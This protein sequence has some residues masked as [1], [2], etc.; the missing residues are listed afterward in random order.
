MEDSSSSTRDKVEDDGWVAWAERCIHRGSVDS[1]LHRVH[2]AHLSGA[3]TRYFCWRQSDCAQRPCSACACTNASKS[4]MFASRF[5]ASRAL[6]TRHAPRARAPKL[7]M[8][9]Y[10]PQHTVRTLSNKLSAYT[11]PQNHS[12]MRDVMCEGIMH[13]D[14]C[15]WGCSGGSAPQRAYQPA[16][17]A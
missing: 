8:V 17:H 2:R 11:C 12:V 6:S 16:A 7:P 3:T 10:A 15:Y 4:K 9:L 1:Y 14:W 13:G 5:R